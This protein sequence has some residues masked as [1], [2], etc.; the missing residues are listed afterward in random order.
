MATQLEVLQKSA[1]TYKTALDKSSTAYSTVAPTKSDLSVASRLSSINNQIESLKSNQRRNMWYGATS[2]AAT[3]SAAGTDAIS[4]KSRGFWGSALKGLQA[5]LNAIAGTAEYAIGQ[6]SDPSY[7]KSLSNATN[8]GLEFTQ[9][10]ERNK[11]PKW[12]ALP[13]GV[14]LDIGLDPVNWATFGSAALIPRVG[15]GAYEGARAGKGIVGALEGAKVGLTSNLA[16]KASKAMN[17]VPFGKRILPWAVA[18]EKMAVRAQEGASAFDKIVGKTVFDRLGKGI[19]GQPSGAIA[20]KV[21][22][23]MNKWKPIEIMGKKTPS[24]ADIVDFFK[25]STSDAMKSRSYQDNLI[26]LLKKKQVNPG[27]VGKEGDFANLAAFENPNA[28]IQRLDKLGNLENIN[29]RNQYTGELLPEYRY[30]LSITNNMENASPFWI[31]Q[32]FNTIQDCFQRIITL[33]EK[34]E[35]VYL[36]MTKF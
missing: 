24:G 11:V 22:E 32:I 23:T 3:P 35:L 27:W 5:P 15:I 6:G 21:E 16:Q 19:F 7:W 14:G 8:K 12:A 18:S 36:G 26:N 25:Y 4:S 33:S 13:I 30:K 29:I 20:K 31:R 1:D 2:T 9:I 10:L 28:T 34:T 17:M